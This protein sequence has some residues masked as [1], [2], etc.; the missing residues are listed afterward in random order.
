MAA[1][2]PRLPQQMPSCP[3][4]PLSS[5]RRP[6]RLFPAT[7]DAPPPCH[8]LLRQQMGLGRG[9]EPGNRFR[10]SLCHRGLTSSLTSSCTTPFQPGTI[11]LMRG[12]AMYWSPSKM[13]SKARRYTVDAS[14][15]LSAWVPVP[16]LPMSAHEQQPVRFL[17]AVISSSNMSMPL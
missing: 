1:A 6:M 5:L 14:I 7:A 8:R 11:G 17:L 15:A 13:A 10:F 2:S 4:S 9:E 3:A 12:H 16:K